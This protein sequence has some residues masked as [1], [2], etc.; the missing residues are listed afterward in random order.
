MGHLRSDEG[1]SRKDKISDQLHFP[2]EWEA[3]KRNRCF[4]MWIGS[5][6]LQRFQFPMFSYKL[7][8]PVAI[9]TPWRRGFLAAV[10]LCMHV[11]WKPC[12]LQLEH[13]IH[14]FL[15]IQ[16]AGVTKKQKDYSKIH[17]QNKLQR[18]LYVFLPGFNFWLELF[19]MFAC[20]TYCFYPR[21]WVH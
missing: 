4:H 13:C 17:P 15:N 20:C 16:G 7:R 9:L 3:Q 1:F 5:V 11:S 12:S 8:K 19:D 18:S 14:H 2:E 21:V 6:G 10:F